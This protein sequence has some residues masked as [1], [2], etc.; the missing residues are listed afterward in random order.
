[1]LVFSVIK[2][3]LFFD[4]CILNFF[5]PYILLEKFLRFKVKSQYVIILMLITCNIPFLIVSK[6]NIESVYQW[7]PTAIWIFM[8]SLIFCKGTYLK[9]IIITIAYVCFNELI[10][11]VT[12]PVTYMTD[13]YIIIANSFYKAEQVRAIINY[14]FLIIL[15]LLYL[16]IL[17]FIVKN[18]YFDYKF[19]NF[20]YTI[21]F[22]VPNV[23]I[24]S[25]ICEYFKLYYKN[26][27]RNYLLGNI[28]MLGFAFTGLICAVF[29]VIT[30][31]KIA[32][33]TIIRERELLLKQQFSIQTQ[34]YKD[35]QVQIK[36]TR[37][38]RHDINNHLICIKNLLLQGDIK[39]TENYLKKITRSLEK[40][41]L[42]VSTGNS[43]ADAVISEKYNISIDKGIDFKCDAKIPS[44]I[45]VDP[46]DLC[47]VLG[48]ALDNAIEACEKITDNSIKKYI[49]ITSTINKSFI[50]FE[51][52]NSMK[53]YIKEKH[54]STDKCDYVNHG[55]GM[56]NI[57]NIADKYFGNT[58]VESRENMFI[59][60]IMFQ[61]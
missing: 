58:Y 31:A 18:H 21:F 16:L 14:I 22:V 3:L 11:Y 46:F 27:M 59:L 50:V 8:F 9:K 60:N 17:N 47:I 33:E 36:N 48:N 56:M 39:S 28:K 12:I 51:I 55:I 37:T 23:F 10:Q 4:S 34:H 29:T 52:K 20:K 25:L 43:F 57:Q 26:N 2:N 5:I 19:K 42:R 40:I 41:S 35:L 6:F 53:G 49:H 15:Q 1:M 61:I 30:L 7:I 13:Y 54:I 32:Q 45:K 44:K 24:V 38:F